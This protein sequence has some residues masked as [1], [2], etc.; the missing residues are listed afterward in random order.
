MDDV[1]GGAS[2]IGKVDDLLG[3]HVPP[4]LDALGL[5]LGGI[6][7]SSTW[8]HVKLGGEFLTYFV[9]D[10]CPHFCWVIDQI[11]MIDHHRS[12]RKGN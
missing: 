2:G 5:E 12:C 10:Y 3:A 1:D 6:D 11:L 7:D 9:L 4:Y 8:L